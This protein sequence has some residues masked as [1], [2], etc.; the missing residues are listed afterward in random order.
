VAVPGSAVEGKV[1]LSGSTT[2]L[3]ITRR[4]LVCRGSPVALMRQV[5]ARPNLEEGTVIQDRPAGSTG[6][7]CWQGK[8]HAARPR[9]D[10]DHVS[11]G[12]R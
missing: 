3:A 7:E 1:V 10:R 11:A 2:D 9:Q 8:R 12:Q 6:T 5:E 4:F